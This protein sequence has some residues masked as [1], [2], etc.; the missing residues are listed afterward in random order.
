MSHNWTL[1]ISTKKGVSMTLTSKKNW[2][3]DLFFVLQ[4]TLAWVFTVPQVARSFSSTAGMTTT[5]SLLCS[6]F[7]I[8]NLWLAVTAYKIARDRKSLQI[9]F[10][11]ANW[12]PLWAIMCV[13]LLTKGHWTNN[14][15]VVMV[16]V[17]VALT[18]L[19]AW[20]RKETIFSTVTEPITRGCVSL[21]VKSTPQLFIAYCIVN[22]GSNKGLAGLTL[23]IGHTTVCLRLCEIYLAA[24]KVGWNKP[25]L[26]L[27][28][29]E[30]GN[31]L[32][33]CITTI[34]WF[35]YK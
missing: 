5:W 4:I 7:I 28:I 17:G 31:E 30:G 25:N 10:V 22:A 6:I 29:S 27:L 2:L 8:V 3:G 19:L 9:V 32:T 33:W 15:S 16:L 35:C 18:I 23:L 14:D 26:G 12:L 21:I 13:V 20:R 11:Y 1:T 24:K 34:A